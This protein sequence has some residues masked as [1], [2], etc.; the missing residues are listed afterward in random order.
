M[1]IALTLDQLIAFYQNNQSLILTA[2]AVLLYIAYYRKYAFY[3][4]H[5][6]RKKLH[7]KKIGKTVP[8]YPNGWFVVARSHELKPKDVK[9]VAVCGQNFVVFRGTDGKAYALDAYC[10]HMG[11]NLGVGGEVTYGNCV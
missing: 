7:K 10:A 3:I 11:A 5:Q 2:I 6:V 8:Y 1:S 9:H 4:C